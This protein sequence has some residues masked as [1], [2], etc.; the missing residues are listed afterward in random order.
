MQSINVVVINPWFMTPFVGTAAAS[1]AMA[2]VSLLRWHDPRAPYWLAGALLYLVGT[3]LVTMVL[4]GISR[5]VVT[6]GKTSCGARTST[7][8]KSRV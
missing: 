7:L 2:I 4:M 3:F 6:D 8:G 5:I 1:V